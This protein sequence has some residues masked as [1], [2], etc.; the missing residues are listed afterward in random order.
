MWA[1]EADGRTHQAE[2]QGIPTGLGT[3]IAR[4]KGMGHSRKEGKS[5]K[6]MGKKAL[7]WRRSRG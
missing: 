4:G 2:R 3:V 6:G 1:R 5:L 7:D